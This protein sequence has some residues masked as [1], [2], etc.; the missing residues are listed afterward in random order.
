MLFHSTTF[1]AFFALVWVLYWALHRH[2]RPKLILLTLA[3]WAFYSAWDWRFTGLLLLSTGVDYV[4]G[5]QLARPNS[6]RGRWLG[7]SLAVNLGILATFKYLDFFAASMATALTSLGLQADW[8]SLHII[9]PVG[10][11][12]YTFQTLG[13]TIDVYRGRA[14]PSDDPWQF[15]AYVAFFPQLVAGPIE[16][17]SSLLPQLAARPRLT[18]ADQLEGARRF[19]IGLWKKMILADNLAVYVDWVFVIPADQ[20]APHQVCLGVLAFAGQIWA[21]FSGYT[22]MALGI[23]RMLGIRLAENFD[24]PYF[25]RGP[26]D[27]WRRWHISLSTWLRDYLYIPLGGNRR[28]PAR[29]QINLAITMLLGGLWHGAAW[30]FVAWGAFHGLW[31][32]LER[33][34]SGLRASLGRERS[35]NFV[36]VSLG[37]AA[38]FV[39]VCLAWLLFRAPS[40][41][42]AWGFVRVAIQGAAN[43]ASWRDPAL[44]IDA[45]FVLHFLG[46]IL[47]LQAVRRALPQPGTETA[48]A[49]ARTRSYVGWMI[50]VYALIALFAEPHA[51]PDAPFIYFQF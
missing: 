20:V 18:A 17:A 37:V 24:A 7:L 45:A 13:Y 40:L 27:F 12:F 47:I 14:Q 23:A 49:H 32:A 16:R 8:A 38:T 4:C 36:W 22:D 48:Q 3:S 46:P 26:R 6:R 25:A 42:V 41:G 19:V 2:T 1:A 15:A 21:D 35:S 5:R 50:A 43:P 34:V 39:M 44:L 33:G 10:I 31:L 9:L 11:S 29:T 51:Q 28:G 30:T